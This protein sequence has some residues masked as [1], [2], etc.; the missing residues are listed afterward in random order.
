VRRVGLGLLVWMCAWSLA[1]PAAARPQP[2][3]VPPAD[4]PVVASVPGATLVA[5][6]HGGKLCLGLR[7]EG[8]ASCDAPPHGLFDPHVEGSSFNV[9]WVT[10]GVTSTDAV[11]VEVL[12]PGKRV[13]APVSGGA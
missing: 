1:G 2:P 8:P 9:T 4:A 5:F 13:T 11:S 12:A 7:G 3:P 6:D 10:Y